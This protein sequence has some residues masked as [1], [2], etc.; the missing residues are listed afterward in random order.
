M[1]SCPVPEIY[2][3]SSELAVSVS[4]HGRAEGTSVLLPRDNGLDEPESAAGTATAAGSRLPGKELGTNSSHVAITQPKR[5]VVTHP[6]WSV[7]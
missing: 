5:F 1:K 2:F 3:A 6:L 7:I 4:S